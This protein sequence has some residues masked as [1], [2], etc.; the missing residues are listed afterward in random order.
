[1]LLAVSLI[2]TCTAL[3]ALVTLLPL[4]SNSHWL[5]RLWDFPRLQLTVVALALLAASAHWLAFSQ[6]LSW[7]LVTTQLLCCAWQLWWVFPY[8]PLAQRHVQKYQRARDEQ[9]IEEHLR[10]LTVNVLQPNRNAIE[11]VRMINRERPDIIIAV[12]TDT[13]WQEQLTDIEDD[14]PHAVKVPQKNLYGMMLYSVWPL[15]NVAVEHLIEEGV[16]SIQADV[17]MPDGQTVRLHCVHPAPP[18][19][20]EN[21]TSQP[22]DR[23]L[24]QIAKRAAQETMPVIV[25]G[26]LNDVAW[27]PTTREFIKL[28]NLQDPRQGRGFFNTFHTQLP[29]LRWPLDHLFHSEHFMLVEMRR[30]PK[31]GSDHFPLLIELALKRPN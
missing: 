12:E 1:M 26:D 5:I 29:F 31:F 25:A 18:S 8:T 7:V 14:F 28:S 16:P 23:E 10:V 4:S 21:E 19:P 9:A 24:I 20:T 2:G 30:L 13:W 27:S 22:R 11:L 3:L 17:E 6:P 15:K